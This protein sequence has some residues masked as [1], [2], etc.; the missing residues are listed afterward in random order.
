VHNEERLLAAALG[1]IDLAF[2]P[3]DPCGID[4]RVAIV[5]DGCTDDS[6]AIAAR[7]ASELAERGGPHRSLVLQSPSAGVGIA[8]AAGCAALLR[9]WRNLDPRGIWLSSTDADSRVPPTWLAAQIEAHERGADLWM[10]RV[11]VEDW[12]QYQEETASLWSTIY[13]RERTPV[14]GANLGCN[15]YEYL[16]VG[17]FR[18]LE[19]GEDRALYESLVARGARMHQDGEVKVISSARRQARAPAGFSGALAAIDDDVGGRALIT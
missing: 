14:H 6:A 3:L 15:A 7:W 19:T 11:E 16:S 8:R 10:G 13:D 2:S 17:G 5:L 1:A 4:C 12:S 9:G 18:S